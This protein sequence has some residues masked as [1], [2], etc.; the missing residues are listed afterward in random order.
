MPSSAFPWQSTQSWLSICMVVMHKLW[1]PY[2]PNKGL[3]QPMESTQEGG[4]ADSLGQHLQGPWHFSS[5]TWTRIDFGWILDESWTQALL[6]S[7]LLS[8]KKKYFL[9]E[10]FFQCRKEKRFLPRGQEVSSKIALGH[11]TFISSIF[12]FVHRLSQ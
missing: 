2:S 12:L 10:N 1:C 7:C 5:G 4:W 9:R 3:S 6:L 11:C 8:S